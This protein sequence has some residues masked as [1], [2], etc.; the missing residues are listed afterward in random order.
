MKEVLFVMIIQS[1]TEN[2]LDSKHWL[3]H[4]LENDSNR[5]GIQEK[6]TDLCYGWGRWPLRRQSRGCP[7]PRPPTAAGGYKDMSSILADQ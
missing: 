2:T 5:C 1:L 7:S 6:V 4:Y 3:K